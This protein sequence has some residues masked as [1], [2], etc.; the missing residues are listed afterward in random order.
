[1]TSM[2]SVCLVG[3]QV[4]NIP[5]N[6]SSEPDQIRT[7]GKGVVTVKNDYF[8]RLLITFANILDPDLPTMSVL[9]WIQT[10]GTLIALLK[11]FLEKVNFEKVSRRQ[12]KHEKLPNMQTFNYSVY[13]RLGYNYIFSRGIVS[14]KHIRFFS[15]SL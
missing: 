6:R 5:G 2:C 11:G 7:N 4:K 14:Y 3:K 1:M 10:F 8:C 12:Q 13:S 9:S 15:S